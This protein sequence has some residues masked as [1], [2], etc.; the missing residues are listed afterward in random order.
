MNFASVSIYHT[1]V[2][3]FAAVAE[4]TSTE[5]VISEINWL[6]LSRSILSVPDLIFHNS[7]ET[8]PDV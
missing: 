7:I 2:T 5:N 6:T 1:F 8:P 4:V 3:S